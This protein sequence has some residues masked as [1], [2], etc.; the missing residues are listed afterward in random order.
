M[1]GDRLK[2]ISLAQ[3]KRTE[4]GIAEVHG[5]RPHGLEH[6]LKLAGRT[7]DDLQHFRGRRLPLTRLGELALEPRDL[8]ARVDRPLCRRRSPRRIRRRARRRTFACGWPA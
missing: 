8:A 1:D 4:L 2:R 5:I 3:V 6:W 7:R